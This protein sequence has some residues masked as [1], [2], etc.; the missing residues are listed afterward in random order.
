MCVYMVGGA[1]VPWGMC[2]DQQVTLWSQFTRPFCVGS[3]D[4]TQAMKLAQQSLNPPSVSP[5]ALVMFL[6]SRFCGLHSWRSKGYK[7]DMLVI[8]ISLLSFPA[9]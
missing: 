9:Q 7:L 1:C 8:F 3:W 5:A 6:S 2:G 4:Q